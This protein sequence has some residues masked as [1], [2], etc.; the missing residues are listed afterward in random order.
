MTSRFVA[1]ARPLVADTPDRIVVDAADRTP[2]KGPL[3][4][5]HRTGFHRLA[6]R[7]GCQRS[8]VRSQDQPSQ[9]DPG[10]ASR[11]EPGSLRLRPSTLR[12]GKQRLVFLAGFV[13]L[14]PAICA[15]PVFQQPFTISTIAG[16]VTQPLPALNAGTS[17]P[18]AIAADTAGNIYFIASGGVY[19]LDEGGGTVTH[20]AGITASGYSGDV[21]MD[22]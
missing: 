8:G 21:L 3:V 15:Q 7:E 14:A 11:L 4:T 5:L 13:G 18:R 19:K 2:W 1:P 9:R 6:N 10:S 22:D 12:T 16:A 17:N 20:I